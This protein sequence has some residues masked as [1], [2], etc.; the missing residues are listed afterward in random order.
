MLQTPLRSFL[1]ADLREARLI[2]LGKRVSLKDRGGADLRNAD[3]TGADLHG[4]ALQGAMLTGARY[5]ARTRW[6]AGFEPAKHGAILT[7]SS[8][9]PRVGSPLV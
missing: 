1:H 6:P 4:A 2:A 7:S 3:L 5:D 9:P 8:H